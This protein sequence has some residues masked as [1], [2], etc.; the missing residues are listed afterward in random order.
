MQKKSKRQLSAASIVPVPHVTA[1]P[2]TRE[3]VRSPGYVSIYS[4]DVQVQTSPWDLRL[5]FSE[6]SD[7]PT[8]ESITVNQLAE[9]RV[10]PQLAKK[11]T[12]VMIQ[13]LTEYEEEFGKIPLKDND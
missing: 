10:S 5:I 4:N 8:P 11:L 9:L 1:R 6:L 2:L 13:L 7:Q 3:I 12:M